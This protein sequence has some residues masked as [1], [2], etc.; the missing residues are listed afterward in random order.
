MFSSNYIYISVLLKSKKQKNIYSRLK[1]FYMS[2]Q[3]N[4]NK[5]IKKR[6]LSLSWTSLF[7]LVNSNSII[8]TYYGLQTEQ[9]V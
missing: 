4:K 7:Q 9:G 2:I 6:C 8:V 3:K 5:Q 1:H